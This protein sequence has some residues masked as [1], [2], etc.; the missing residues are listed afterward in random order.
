MKLFPFR[1]FSRR[2]AR[3]PAAET[4]TAAAPPEAPQPPQ[5][6]EEILPL[7][8]FSMQA[9]PWRQPPM[10]P[11]AIGT[12]SYGKALHPGL[13]T[14]F[15]QAGPGTFLLLGIT[16]EAVISQTREHADV[17]PRA[18]IRGLVLHPILPAKGSGM[19]RLIFDLRQPD[20]GSRWHEFMAAPVYSEALQTWCEARA[21]RLADLLALP[22]SV[23]SPSHDC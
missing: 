5:P 2:E 3:P 8:D 19:V 21:R 22:L 16:A 1:L 13:M 7:P 12:G 17:L 23:E 11:Y 18:D 15:Q 4:A 20:G 10:A 6:L 9:V 14:A